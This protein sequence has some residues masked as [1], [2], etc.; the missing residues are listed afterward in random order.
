MVMWYARLK[1]LSIQ[2]PLYKRTVVLM[3]VWNMGL[4]MS[5]EKWKRASSVLRDKRIPMRLNDKLCESLVRPTIIGGLGYGLTPNTWKKGN[6]EGEEEEEK[7][8]VESHLFEHI[9]HVAGNLDD[10]I[11]NS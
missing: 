6:V 2:G 3:R 11:Y 9:V 10:Y 4:S 8:Y 1:V 5:R 7:V